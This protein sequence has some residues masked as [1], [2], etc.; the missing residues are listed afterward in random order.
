MAQDARLQNLRAIDLG[1]ANLAHMMA[2]CDRPERNAGLQRQYSELLALRKSSE[3]AFVYPKP[4]QQPLNDPDLYAWKT[5]RKYRQAC[6][7]RIQ[8]SPGLGPQS[9]CA[10]Y[11]VVRSREGTADRS[12]L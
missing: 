8:R 11:R 5:D 6:H 10:F 7:P 12:Q 2:N 1:L 9:R 3:V 4:K